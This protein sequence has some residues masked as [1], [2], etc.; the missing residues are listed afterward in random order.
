VPH[1]FVLHPVAALVLLFSVPLWWIT[2]LQWLWWTCH[3]STLANFTACCL[4]AFYLLYSTTH[5]TWNTSRVP[6]PKEI[7]VITQKACQLE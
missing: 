2:A 4:S 6:P 3:W 1:I 7:L 5:I